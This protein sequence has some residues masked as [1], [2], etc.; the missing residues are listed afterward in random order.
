[1]VSP[2][3]RSCVADHR[4]GVRPRSAT[5]WLKHFTSSFVR[6]TASF[7]RATSDFEHPTSS[8]DNSTS[9]FV[10]RT[11]SVVASASLS[12]RCA[13]CM[14]SR[15][16]VLPPSCATRGAC[17]REAMALRAA[18]RMACA[19]IRWRTVVLRD[20]GAVGRGTKRRRSSRSRATRP[21]ARR[22]SRCSDSR[23]S[24]SCAWSAGRR[25]A[26]RR[27]SG[28]PSTQRVTHMVERPRA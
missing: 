12:M 28:R 1:M 18:A 9:E 7:V 8:C 24:R 3:S 26:L 16:V 17:R 15:D 21:A 13:P 11:A 14:V 27:S 25:G 2:C 4:L 23:S 10:A 5:T 6:M 19:A 20:G 22:R